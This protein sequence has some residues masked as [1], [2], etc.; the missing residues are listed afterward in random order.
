MFNDAACELHVFS[1]ASQHAYGVCAYIR[2]V[3]KDAKIYTMLISAKSK[4]APTKATTIPRLELQAAVMASHMKCKIQSAM[5]IRFV[6]AYMWTDSKVVLG[7]INN[8]SRRFHVYVANRVNIIRE[9]TSPEDWN[10][11]SSAQNPADIPS[12]GCDV[13]GIDNVWLHGPSF[14]RQFKDEWE[15]D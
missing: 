10:Y 9:A 12:R 6:R 1:D 15:Q 5:D 11:I 3:S 2:A 8:E 13:T 14:L 4:V 7:Y